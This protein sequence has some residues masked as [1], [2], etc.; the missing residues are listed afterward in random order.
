M[1]PLKSNGFGELDMQFV[2][3]LSRRVWEKSFDLLDWVDYRPDP[4]WWPVVGLAAALGAA[5]LFLPLTLFIAALLFSVVAAAG[6]LVLWA[7]LMVFGLF[8]EAVVLACVDW[9]RERLRERRRRARVG[10]VQPRGV[11]TTRFDQTR[12]A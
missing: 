5:Y 11:I 8:H 4:H 1:P 2:F 9:V 7:M 12:Q 10:V 3:R 6:L